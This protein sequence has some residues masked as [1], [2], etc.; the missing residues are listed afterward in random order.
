M[1]E[2][3]NEDFFDRSGSY[4][5][6]RYP[7]FYD[8]I[9]AAYPQLNIVATTPVTSRPMDVLDEHFYNHDPYYF[10]SNAHMFD[11]ASRSGPNV[12]SSRGGVPSGR[13]R[14]GESCP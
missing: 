10:A 9:K 4:N 5:A 3:D 2:I 13:R 8:A 1:V 11:T 7:M 14:G 12:T 6:Y